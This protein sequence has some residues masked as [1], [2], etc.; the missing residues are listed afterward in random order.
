MNNKI[1]INNGNIDGWRAKLSDPEKHWKEGH[2]ARAAAYCWTKSEEYPIEIYRLLNECGIDSPKPF[3]VIP[4]YKV[5]LPPYG[6]AASQ[7]D[8]FVLSKSNSDGVAV[9]MIEAK[10]DEPFDKTIEKW[11]N[12]ENKTGR[13]TRLK[14]L[15]DKLELKNE[16]S[17]LDKYYYQLFH[18]TVSAIIT[19]EEI[20]ASKAIMIVHSFS[21]SN[22]WID[23][24]SEFIKV[25]NESIDPKVD[26]IH[27]IKKLQNKIDLYIGWA[28]GDKKYLTK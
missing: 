23:K 17:K 13:E 1:Y 19:A 18:R 16:F 9:I 25:L 22:K 12:V 2:S 14:F 28:K 11:M 4:E 21:Q 5:D 7:N 3:I 15:C 6:R 26:T 24:Y 10:V 8:I 20:G 27:H